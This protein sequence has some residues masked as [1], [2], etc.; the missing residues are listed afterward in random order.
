METKIQGVRGMLRRGTSGVLLTLLIMFAAVFA[1]SNINQVFAF[2]AEEEAA[3]IT[4]VTADNYTNVSVFLKSSTA[5]RPSASMFNVTRK[6]N[7][8][9]DE[10]F[11]W[12]GGLSQWDSEN[13]V[14]VI[15]AIPY[16]QGSKYIVTDK[17]DD[18]IQNEIEDTTQIDLSNLTLKLDKAPPASINAGNVDVKRY[19]ND[20]LETSFKWYGGYSSWDSSTNTLIVKYIVLPEIDAEEKNVRYSVGYNNNYVDAQAF[21]LNPGT[22]EP[23]AVQSV[24]LTKYVALDITLGQVP[25]GYRPYLS[26]IVLKRYIYGVQDPSFVWHGGG[27]SGWDSTHN[28]LSVYYL[29]YSEGVHYEV[30]DMPDDNRV[31]IIQKVIQRI[32]DN[33]SIRLNR[34]PGNSYLIPLTINRSVNGNLRNISSFSSYF[35]ILSGLLR[36]GNI[37]P[38]EKSY[39]EAKTIVYS[40]ST[41]STPA[42]STDPFILEV[43]QLPEDFEVN[44][45]K[46]NASLKAG[47]TLQLSATVSP[48]SVDNKSIIWSVSNQSTFNVVSVS[49]TGLVTAL[50]AGTAVIRATSSAAPSYYAECTV[51]VESDQC[52]VDMNGEVNILDLKELSNNYN[53]SNTQSNWNPKNDFNN[54]GRVDLFDLTIAARKIQYNDLKQAYVHPNLIISEIRLWGTFLQKDLDSLI[55]YDPETNEN[56]VDAWTIN[57]SGGNWGDFSKNVNVTFKSTYNRGMGLISGKTYKI[58][59]YSRGEAASSTLLVVNEPIIYSIRTPFVSTSVNKAFVSIASK[60]TD[61]IWSQNIKFTLVNELG[62]I[63]YKQD[64]LLREDGHQ[65]VIAFNLINRERLNQSNKL[66]LSLENQGSVYLPNQ[67]NNEIFK[68]SGSIIMGIMFDKFSGSAN[69]TTNPYYDFALLGYNLEGRTGNVDIK[70]STGKVVLTTTWIA[71]KTEDGLMDQ[72]VIKVKKTDIQNGR[73]NAVFSEF[74]SYGTFTISASREQ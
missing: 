38:E 9:E 10:G 2:A 49:S 37:T 22:T 3:R 15:E 19:I 36:A 23:L 65:C 45:D 5:S 69:D 8:I 72:I 14:L 31:L 16:V 52:D 35:D 28:I 41:G 42:A 25:T 20:V 1:I 26:D 53:T 57:G 11:R 6:I 4:E 66:F 24:S 61:T 48:D 67:A 13:M 40:V 60:E 18:G 70:E 7:G 71:E 56:V 43:E 54:D 44:M 73:Y 29:P 58:V 68:R 63:V 34:A 50:K 51:T 32:T 33:L 46:D 47:Q 39:Q 62:E 74:G 12:K 27:T 30:S 21:K 64:N 17:E 55:I 59:V